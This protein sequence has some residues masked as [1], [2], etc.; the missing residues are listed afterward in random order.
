MDTVVSVY[1]TMY[2]DGLHSTVQMIK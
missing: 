1:L 2:S